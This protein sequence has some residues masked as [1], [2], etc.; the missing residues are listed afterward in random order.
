M[1]NSCVSEADTHLGVLRE[2]ILKLS[3]HVSVSK[4]KLSSINASESV[5]IFSISCAAISDSPGSP[6]YLAHRQAARHVAVLSGKSAVERRASGGFGHWG[7]DGQTERRNPVTEA[8]PE[9]SKS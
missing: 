2:M 1:A 4:G 8:D 5:N 6:R 3:A 9:S 7:K